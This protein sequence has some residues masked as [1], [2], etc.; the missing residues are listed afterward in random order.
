MNKNRITL[1]D[2]IV[3]DEDKLKKCPSNSRTFYKYQ[4][5]TKGFLNN[6]NRTLLN[7]HRHYCDK[8]KT[9]IH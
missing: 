1:G 5:E 7:H 8:L 6:E 3:I 2:K 4:C 9:Q